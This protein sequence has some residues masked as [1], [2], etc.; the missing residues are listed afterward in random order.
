MDHGSDDD[1][2]VIR[3][4][5]R[6]GLRHGFTRPFADPEERQ[7]DFQA[8]LD[9][10]RCR[11]H[12]THWVDGCDRCTVCKVALRNK[13]RERIIARSQRFREKAEAILRR[14]RRVIFR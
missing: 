4:A 11:R 6:F 14:T 5:G 2:A 1:R 13:D 9:T 10:I 3:Q 12:G 7:E 8:W